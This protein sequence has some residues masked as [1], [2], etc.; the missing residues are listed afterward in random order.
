MD[1]LHHLRSGFFLHHWLVADITFLIS[2][3]RSCWR[4]H[5]SCIQQQWK[6][7]TLRII[8]STYLRVLFRIVLLMVTQTIRS[9]RSLL[10]IIAHATSQV[11][12]LLHTFPR[13]TVSVRTVFGPQKVIIDWDPHVTHK[14]LAE[15]WQL[16]FADHVHWI[17]QLEDHLRTIVHSNIYLSIFRI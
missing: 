1:F 8:I 6:I 13:I 2:V 9:L 17:Q 10:L 12:N 3:L 16:Y 4:Q 15:A 14:T 7:I 11:M 5:I